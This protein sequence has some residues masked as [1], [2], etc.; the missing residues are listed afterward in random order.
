MS[1]EPIAVLAVGVALGGVMLAGQRA[2]RAEVA[3]PR[4]D[5]GG[6]RERMA[7]LEG[8]LEGLRDA[9]AGRQVA[10]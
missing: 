4:R 2:T 6:L 1:P 3:E 9:I 5:V 8:L 7:R 10:E